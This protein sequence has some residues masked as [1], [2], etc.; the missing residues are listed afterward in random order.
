[1]II[2]AGIGLER[3]V[4]VCVW[5]GGDRGERES[6]KAQRRCGGLIADEIGHKW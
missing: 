5:R 6:S 4:G 2:V 1:L 3:G